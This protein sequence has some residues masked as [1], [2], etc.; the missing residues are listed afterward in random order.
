MHIL[1]ARG[2]AEGAEK[3]IAASA[4]GK[5]INPALT[6]IGS[7]P[8]LHAIPPRPPRLRV[9]Q[10]EKKRGPRFRGGD[11]VE[12]SAHSPTTKLGCSAANKKAMR[13]ARV[14]H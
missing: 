6:G 11:E 12:T 7:I 14:S 5:S 2:G 9:N 4:A 13:F 1:Y 8:A 10:K 3:R